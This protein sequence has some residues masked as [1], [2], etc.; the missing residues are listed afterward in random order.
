M[1]ECP[2]CREDIK[3]NAIICKHCG[4]DVVPVNKPK[5]K[6]GC[7]QNFLLFFIITAVLGFV[8]GLMSDSDKESTSVDTKKKEVKEKVIVKPS[9]KI[10]KS[11]KSTKTKSVSYSLGYKI[12]TIET[13]N[14]LSEN[15]LI[16][17]RYN[18]LLKQLDN[19]YVESENRISEMTLAAY[20]QLLDDGIKESMVN[21]MEGLNSVFSQKQPN[22][23][24]AEY[25][26]IYVVMRKSG[27]SHY[28]TIKD[29]KALLNTFGIY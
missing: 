20:Q 27:V 7:F 8:F 12:A 19:K 17:K 5:K 10:K 2:F 9:K 11:T 18:S 29:I 16:V 23:K 6:R 22:I 3:E 26:S 13:G 4:S 14:Y 1:R 15:D 28:D 24:Y 25:V 21:I